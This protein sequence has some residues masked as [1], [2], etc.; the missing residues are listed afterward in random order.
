MSFLTNK[1]LENLIQFSTIKNK[2]ISENISN[3]STKDYSRKDV[4]F[5]NILASNMSAMKSTNEKHV[6][7]NLDSPEFQIITEKNGD[8]GSGVTNVNIDKE[9]ADLAENSIRYKFATRKL[10][11]YYKNLQEVIKGD[12]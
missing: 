2:V 3:I 8:S 6:G 12:K 11:L 1:P 10:G 5:Q 9:M 7:N 4:S